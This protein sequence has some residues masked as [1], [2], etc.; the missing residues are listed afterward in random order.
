MED[1][2]AA[3]ALIKG[4]DLQQGFGHAGGIGAVNALDVEHHVRR[5]RSS[6]PLP[7]PHA[8]DTASRLWFPRRPADAAR[9]GRQRSPGS[10]RRLRCR[11][12]RR[13][14]RSGISTSCT[15]YSASPMIVRGPPLS[16]DGFNRCAISWGVN[17][18]PYSDAGLRIT[19]APRV[20]SSK[21]RPLMLQILGL[22][23][24]HIPACAA[25]T[26]RPGGTSG[27][28]AGRLPD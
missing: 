5:N 6:A 20:R 3:A 15:G 22:L 14:L 21:A 19:G 2:A 12:G 11:D 18:L 9:R 10:S 27:R 1:R 25:G 7:G 8:A 23:T 4:R 13:R 16:A 26:R 28:C 17:S 24:S